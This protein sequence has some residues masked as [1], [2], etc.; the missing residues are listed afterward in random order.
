MVSNVELLWIK[1]L[2]YWCTDFCVNM[3]SCLWYK[4][5]GAKFL[6]YDGILVWEKKKHLPNPT[7]LYHHQ[8]Y[9]S[10]PFSLHLC[11][12]LVLLLLFILAILVGMGS[13]LIV[14]LMH[15]S[16]LSNNEEYLFMCLFVISI[17]TLVICLFRCFVCVLTG[18]F[19]FFTV[20]FWEFFLKKLA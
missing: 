18:L 10:S 9:V 13:F 16:L 15:I 17:S 6:G 12:N 19:A 3:S 20:E 5:P 7:I 1:L 14:V 2:Q 4:C 11:Q 8:Q